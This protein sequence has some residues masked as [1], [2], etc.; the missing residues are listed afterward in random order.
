VGRDCVVRRKFRDGDA[1]DG[2]AR[3]REGK[4]GIGDVDDTPTTRSEH[5]LWRGSGSALKQ[6]CNYRRWG[7]RMGV[8][9]KMSDS[10]GR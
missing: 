7:C 2:G 4:G 3:D 10:D 9:D 5:S 1:R 6:L 8:G